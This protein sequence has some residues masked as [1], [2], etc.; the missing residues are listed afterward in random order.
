MVFFP[1]AISICPC[2]II[3]EANDKAE[4]LSR[5][6]Y[7]FRQHRRNF[8]GFAAGTMCQSGS[9]WV[10]GHWI[11]EQLGFDFPKLLFRS[12]TPANLS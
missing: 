11:V 3:D 6:V 9:E 8:E 5:A 10:S 2:I 7:P 12:M 1:S 4:V